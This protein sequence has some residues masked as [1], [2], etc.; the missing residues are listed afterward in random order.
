MLN[1]RPERN[2]RKNTTN[3]QQKPGF[4]IGHGPSTKLDGIF[5]ICSSYGFYFPIATGIM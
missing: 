5:F 3:C 1:Y 2:K 4:K